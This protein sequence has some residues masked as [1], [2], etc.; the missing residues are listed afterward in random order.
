[1]Q[2]VS[3]IRALIFILYHSLRREV[4]SLALHELGSDQEKKHEGEF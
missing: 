1:M 4:R 2:A 3:A